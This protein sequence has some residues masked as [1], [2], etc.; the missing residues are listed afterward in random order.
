MTED[1]TH[2]P[3]PEFRAQLEWEIARTYR[4]EARLGALRHEK[5][6]RWLRGAAIVVACIGMGTASG[7]ATA[8]V[9]YN[10]QRDSLLEAA[11][12]ELEMISLRLELARARAGD[13]MKEVKIGAAGTE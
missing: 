6:G 4:R 11:H 3:A 5:R 1:T 2:T 10:V 8:Q 9:R 12:A 13:V 7:L